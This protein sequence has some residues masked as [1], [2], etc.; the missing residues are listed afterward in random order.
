MVKKRRLWRIVKYLGVHMNSDLT[1]SLNVSHT[2]RRL[3]FQRR[4]E[5]GQTAH[6]APGELLQSILCQC[7]T[8]QTDN[9]K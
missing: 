1:W 8:V 5:A 4:F 3:F 6:S 2:Q 7:V 9:E